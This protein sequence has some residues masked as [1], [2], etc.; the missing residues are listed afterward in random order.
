MNHNPDVWEMENDR[1]EM[2]GLL[3]TEWHFKLLISTTAVRSAEYLGGRE[4]NYQFSCV[5]IVVKVL[6]QAT[7]HLGPI[8]TDFYSQSRPPTCL[9]RI[10]EK[11]AL[12][13]SACRRDTRTQSIDVWRWDLMSVFCFIARPAEAGELQWRQ[14]V[15]WSWTINLLTSPADVKCQVSVLTF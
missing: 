5:K 4:Q 12:N 11:S 10:R 6:P 8:T 2:E 1:K 3:Y 15:C 7:G 14:G 13:I 9:S